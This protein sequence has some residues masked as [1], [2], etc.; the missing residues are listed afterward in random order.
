MNAAKYVTMGFNLW[1]PH[2]ADTACTALRDVY[3]GNMKAED[4]LIKMTKTL[5]ASHVK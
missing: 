3:A 1:T 4:A 5:K 2:F